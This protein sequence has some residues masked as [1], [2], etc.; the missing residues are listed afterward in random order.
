[1]H[2][3]RPQMPDGYGVPD[4]TDGLLEWSVVEQ[5]LV[6]AAHVWLATTRPDGRPHVVP[7]WGVWLDGRYHYDGSPE[8]V[9]ARNLRSNPACTLHL[10]SGKEAV[11]VEGTSG[12]SEPVVGELGERLSAAFRAK[13][14]A[15]GYEPGPDSWSGEDAGGLCVLRPRT[16][17][18][19]FRFPADV[20]RFRFGS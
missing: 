18:A 15:D 7:R 10:E 12:P 2:I 4:T 9:H 17:L 20:T 19:W 8:T 6:D 5:R 13:Y 16:A 11:I 1:M 3:D 14:A